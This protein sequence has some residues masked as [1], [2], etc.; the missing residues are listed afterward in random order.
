MSGLDKD[1]LARLEQTVERYNLI[2]GHLSRKEWSLEQKDFASYL[3]L[4]LVRES[5]DFA[6]LDEKLAA[7]DKTVSKYSTNKN[8]AANDCTLKLIKRLEQSNSQAL[9]QAFSNDRS[10]KP[11]QKLT[12]DYF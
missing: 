8:H 7:I 11:P 5:D 10:F 1:S 9:A 2:I 3:V 12:R 4:H 6:N